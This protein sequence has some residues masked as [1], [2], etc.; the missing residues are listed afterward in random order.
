MNDQYKNLFKGIIIFLVTA[1]IL[2]F[3]SIILP[4]C[5]SRSRPPPL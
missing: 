5:H 3:L 4:S 2:L 1:V